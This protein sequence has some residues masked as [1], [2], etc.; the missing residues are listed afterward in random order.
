MEQHNPYKTPTSN[1]ALSRSAETYQPQ[2][3]ATKGRIGRLRY[4]AYVW[5]GYLFMIPVTLIGGIASTSGDSYSN[6]LSGPMILVISIAYI[7]MIVFIFIL[8]KRRLND[9]N[10]TGWL[11]LIMLIPLVNILFGLY[12]IFAPGKPDHNRFGPP[13]TKN[14]ILVKIA[15]LALPILLIGIMA[16][17]AIP[18]YQDYV[19]RAQEAS[20]RFQG[21]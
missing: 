9:L 19:T 20:D 15:G 18:A 2:V 10:H 21:Q 4:L 11:A 6:S 13:P 7:T 3:F 5:V 8:A 16:T 12:I 1:T 17:V 14:S